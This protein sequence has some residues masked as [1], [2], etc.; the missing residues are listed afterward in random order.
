MLLAACSRHRSDP[1]S[2]ESRPSSR[3]SRLQV[4][5]PSSPRA[6]PCYAVVSYLC[7]DERSPSSG[8]LSAPTR[9]HYCRSART[10]TYTRGAEPLSS[11]MLSRGPKFC[12]FWAET[13]GQHTHRREPEMPVPPT[14]HRRSGSFPLCCRAWPGISPL[15]RMHAHVRSFAGVCPPTNTAGPF[16]A[17]FPFFIPLPRAR[18]QF[19]VAAMTAPSVFGTHTNAHNRG[20]EPPVSP[21]CD[22]ARHSA[23]PSPRTPMQRR[24]CVRRAID[25]KFEPFWPP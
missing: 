5:L 9:L 4:P 24:T 23:V 21:I 3:A 6:L 15:G 16:L 11:L 18:H 20:A 7:S 10:R 14:C 13:H 17:V 25:P 1:P 12:L 8:S 2:L 19:R 22:R